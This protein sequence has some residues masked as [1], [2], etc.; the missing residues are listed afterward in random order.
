MYDQSNPAN[1][2]SSPVSVSIAAG[3]KDMK[4]SKLFQKFMQQQNPGSQNANKNLYANIG[5]GLKAAQEG[6]DSQDG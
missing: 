6:Q 4:Q 5:K 2:K 3:M 1:K